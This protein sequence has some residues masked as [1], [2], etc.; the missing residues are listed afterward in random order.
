MAPGAVPEP[1]Q[2]EQPT[3]DE[4]LAQAEEI[5]RRVERQGYCLVYLT[6]L[7]DVVAFARDDAVAK[8]PPGYVVYTQ[9]EVVE[10][11]GGPKSPPVRTLR[12]LHEAKKLRGRVVGRKLPE[13]RDGGPGA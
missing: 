4:A 13:K 6:L 12:L 9:S 7:D 8:V 3:R 11:Y 10:L 5:A 1:H 2:P